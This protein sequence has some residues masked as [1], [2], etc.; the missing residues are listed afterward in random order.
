MNR[1]NYTDQELIKLNQ[2]LEKIPTEYQILEKNPLINPLEL[3]TFLSGRNFLTANLHF[4]KTWTPN[5]FVHEFKDMIS[6]N[7][8]QFCSEN[9]N[10]PGRVNFS[11][12]QLRPF[13][14]QEMIQYLQV[15]G[16]LLV[17]IDG[18]NIQKHKAG[19]IL[20]QVSKDSNY[21]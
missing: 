16:P 21:V 6:K 2:L 13:D 12:E 9:S 1:K 18:T 3:L 5:Q 17:L 4:E 20:H 8:L 7:F 15:K 11:V 10:F 19:Q 14:E